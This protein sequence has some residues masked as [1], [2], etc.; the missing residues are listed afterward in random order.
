[1]KFIVVGGCGFVGSNFV[2]QALDLGHEVLVIDNL[3]SGRVEFINSQNS[4]QRL[5][6]IIDDVANWEKYRHKLTLSD[7]CVHLAS[8]ADIAAAIDDPTIDFY[9]GTLISQNVA[10]MVRKCRIPNVVYAS[11]SGVYGEYDLEMDE[12]LTFR[13]ISPYGASKVAGESIFCSYSYMYEINTI[14]LR[15]ANVVGINQTHGVGFD[16]I[17]Q[18]KKNSEKLKVLGNGNQSKSY[19][20][21]KDVV[22]AI[23]FLLNQNL[24]SFNVYNVTTPDQVTVK[25]IAH[26]AIEEVYGKTNM[27]Q[28]EYQDSDRGWRGD[29]PSVILSGKKLL[30]QGWKTSLNSR[31]AIMLS[32]HQLNQQLN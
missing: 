11:G 15:F 30:S 29:V 10:E 12:D 16:F 28:I 19:I 17:K 31:Q 32:L 24:K 2:K 21:V 1:M 23:L 5:E 3:K 27:T 7:V 18:L 14:A 6:I 4:G 20:H 22:S 9:Q 25:D 26:L 8:N 13:P